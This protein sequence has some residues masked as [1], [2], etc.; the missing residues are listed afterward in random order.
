MANLVIADGELFLEFRLGLCADVI[1]GV[2]GK[3]DRGPLPVRRELQLAHQR[4]EAV[5]EGFDRCEVMI[6]LLVH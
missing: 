4:G 6:A 5:R 3:K 2:D 1:R